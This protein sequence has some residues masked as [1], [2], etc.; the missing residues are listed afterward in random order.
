MTPKSMSASLLTDQS[1]IDSGHPN[2]GGIGVGEDELVP[3]PQSLNPSQPPIF[4][5]ETDRRLTQ[6]ALENCTPKPSVVRT[7][8]FDAMS[9]PQKMFKDQESA[10]MLLPSFKV[11]DS[12]LTMQKTLSPSPF[13]R[14]SKMTK[15]QFFTP[16]PSNGVW[17]P[18]QIL[19][20][21]TTP[22]SPAPYPMLFSPSPTPLR[23]KSSL[24]NKIFNPNEDIQ[25]LVLDDD[26]EDLTVKKRPDQMERKERNEQRKSPK[27]TRV[28]RALYPI[29]EQLHFKDSSN[30]CV[31]KIRLEP[32]GLTPLSPTKMP[33]NT[34]N[35]DLA[36]QKG[37]DL[38]T[39]NQPS[40]PNIRKGH[41]VKKIAELEI[42]VDLDM[43]VGSRTLRSSL[44]SANSK[45]TSIAKSS[46]QGF[47]QKK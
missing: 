31:K 30:L 43:P 28:K 9:T 37:C 17:S 15:G 16:P 45:I 4:S 3:T 11:E 36:Q 25:P 32:L 38:W 6:A 39:P 1:E 33:L 27:V 35:V 10:D 23:N 44:C 12:P 47:Q 2:G 21:G 24:N 18:G 41:H 5:P 26:K 19:P 13:S 40:L 46:H 22:F 42:G 7:L 14:K 20:F 8:C 34:E 29:D